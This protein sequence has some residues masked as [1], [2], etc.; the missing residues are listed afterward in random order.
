MAIRSVMANYQFGNVLIGA[1]PTVIDWHDSSRGHL[2]SDIA[3][4]TTFMTLLC[5]VLNTSAPP[6]ARNL[7]AAVVRRFHRQYLDAYCH[8]RGP[9]DQDELRRWTFVCGLVWI[10]RFELTLAGIVGPAQAVDLIRRSNQYIHNHF[11]RDG[12]T[13]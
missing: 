10:S 8:E 4:S 11:E 9:L 12:R 5:D 3:M 13:D 1:R 7:L 2:V 6:V